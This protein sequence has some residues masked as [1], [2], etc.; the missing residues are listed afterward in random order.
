LA[1]GSFSLLYVHLFVG[2]VLCATSVGIT[3]RVFKD[4]G[5]LQTREA[6]IILGAAVIDDA[7]FSAIVIM[8]MVTTLVTPPLLKIA[9]QKRLKKA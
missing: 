6:Q 3:A 5:K 7:A 8:V 2:A 9:L 1:P 4:L